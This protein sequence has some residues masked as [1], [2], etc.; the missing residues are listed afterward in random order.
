MAN[1]ILNA[2]KAELQITDTLSIEVFTTDDVDVIYGYAWVES[3]G[4]DKKKLSEKKGKYYLPRLS[5]A[6]KQ[7]ENSNP[8]V[9]VK[10]ISETYNTLSRL[11]F[12]EVLESLIRLCYQTKRVSITYLSFQIHTNRQKVAKIRR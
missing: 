5:D 1:N 7:R 11:E 3:F 9:K 12:T 4:I 6:Y 8:K 10:G 2:R